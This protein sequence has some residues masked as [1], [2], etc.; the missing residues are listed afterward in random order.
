MRY[1]S[2]L[3]RLGTETAFDVLDQVK[4]LEAQG[5]SIISFALGEPDFDTPTNI[6]EAAKQAL[7]E[8][9]TH[10]SP[11]AGLPELRERLAA[12][13][14]RTR[15]VPVSPAEIVVT[16][17]AKKIILDTM[18]ACV[19]EGE[20]VLYP[21]PGYPIYESIASFIGADACPVPMDPDTGFGFNLDELRRLITPNTRL[22]VLNSPQNP[23]GG[24]LEAREIEVIAKLTVE[25]DLWVLSDEIYSRLCY[26]G[27]A[28][29]PA[30]IP[31]LKERVIVLDG[32]SK[33]YAMTGWRVGWAM[34]N[35]E[36]AQQLAKLVT[37]A[38][39]CA[40]TFSQWATLE[41][42]DGP[43]EEADYMR[44]EFEARRELIVAG[45]N[46]I[47]GIQCQ[48]PKGA[49]YVFPEVTDACRAKGF[50]SS[51]ELQNYLLFEGKVAV[52]HR[53]CFGR[54]LPGESREFIRL[55]YATSRQQIEAGLERIERAL[56]RR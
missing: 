42:L 14:E 13:M 56:R 18:L 11:S 1:A 3:S 17:G 31:G 44:Q 25:H 4:A 12:Y 8:G 37:N 33:T 54:K 26:D 49:F 50:R 47:E 22:L 7:D 52:L 6:R 46:S 39:S 41:A 36:L 32:A 2:R 23:T 19:N 30:S 53:E 20:R 5:E 10:Y 16:P 34:C 24:V 55:S 21:S 51:R 27:E 40:S 35:S 29:S 9:K 15:G 43:Q 38:D 45:L 28:L 48:S